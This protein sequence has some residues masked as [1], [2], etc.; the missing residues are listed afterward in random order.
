MK[1][2]DIFKDTIPAIITENPNKDAPMGVA[3]SSCSGL[4]YFAV[5]EKATGKIVEVREINHITKKEKFVFQDKKYKAFKL[6]NN[7][8]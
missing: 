8:K 6:K 3:N 4:G 2:P 7:I 5:G 1:I